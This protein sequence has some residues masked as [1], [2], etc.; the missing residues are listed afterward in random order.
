[1]P[2]TDWWP[3][4]RDQLGSRFD[5]T[6]ADSDHAGAVTGWGRVYLGLRYAVLVFNARVEHPVQI[7]KFHSGEWSF[8]R[9]LG[10]RRMD[11]PSAPIRAERIASA[12]SQ[13]AL[14]ELLDGH[15]RGLTSGGS[16]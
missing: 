5:P 7:T 10:T 3:A 9:V 1:M 16:C 8:S 15:F 2:V 14:I 13:D 6:A 11:D 12:R 4:M